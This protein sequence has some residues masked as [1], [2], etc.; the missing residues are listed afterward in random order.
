MQIGLTPIE[1]PQE[2]MWIG[3]KRNDK[4]NGKGNVKKQGEDVSLNR[5][6]RRF[7]VVTGLEYNK[8]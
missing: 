8:V 3:V 2:T 6:S 4:P 5:R 7:L 1:E